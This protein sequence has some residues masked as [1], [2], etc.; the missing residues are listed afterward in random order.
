ML[1]GAGLVSVIIGS[2]IMYKEIA[3]SW[4]IKTKKV[5]KYTRTLDRWAKPE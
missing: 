3:P 4:I 2:C 1:H 5:K